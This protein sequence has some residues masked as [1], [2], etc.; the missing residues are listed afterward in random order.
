MPEIP[1]KTQAL[2][3][4][5]ANLGREQ[6]FDLP[7][8]SEKQ[9]LQQFGDIAKSGTDLIKIFSAR[10]DKKKKEDDDLAVNEAYMGYVA[11][12]RQSEQELYALKGAEAQGVTTKFKHKAEKIY[13]NSTVD[14]TEDQRKIFDPEVIRYDVNANP[15]M[16]IYERD[17]HQKRIRD[18]LEGKA[19]S[20]TVQALDN[21]KN[22]VLFYRDI[23]EARQLKSERLR[24]DG[25]NEN[26]I[27]EA[28]RVF[29]SHSVRAAIE[30]TARESLPRAKIWFNE[31]KKD[32]QFT[33]KDRNNLEDEF[34]DAGKRDRKEQTELIAQ[35]WFDTLKEN[36]EFVD[37]KLFREDAVKRTKKN[38]ALRK[39]MFAQVDS[40]DKRQKDQHATNQRAIIE[41]VK[42]LIDMSENFDAANHQINVS[43][44]GRDSDPETVRILRNYLKTQ[45]ITGSENVKTKSA[46]LQEGFTLINKNIQGTAQPHEVINS[47][48]ELVAR[49]S[50]LVS[51]P[52]MKKLLDF[53][54]N[55]G[56]LGRNTYDS[57]FD[58]YVRLIEEPSELVKKDKTKQEDFA[59]YLDYIIPR[60]D[61]EKVV[62]DFDLNTIGAGYFML[63][64]EGTVFVPDAP[65][66][67]AGFDELIE[68]NYF[69]AKEK[70]RELSWLPGELDEAQLN[71]A[72]QILAQENDERRALGKSAIKETGRIL[73]ELYKEQIMR[74]PHRRELQ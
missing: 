60:L 5:E 17:A 57:I 33:I 72:R 49:L 63:G 64:K 41:Q 1:Q 59:R 19:I 68:E 48:N 21:Y 61:P 62:N 18:N 30:Q 44:F 3:P 29:L 36:N 42:V 28:D 58:S 32:G 20:L 66:W 56:F 50:H 6:A 45:K 23:N 71:L 26:K 10:Q 24:L 34:K 70:G 43:T 14:L 38:P 8:I 65:L 27:K 7:G 40:Y 2:T 9:M 52:D 73:R 39:A 47:Y 51:P 55:G 13:R 54:R 74:L 67:S 16:A 69:E 31:A 22:K 53:K 25:V 15:R 12:M 4:R 35:T 37:K 46:S 11:A